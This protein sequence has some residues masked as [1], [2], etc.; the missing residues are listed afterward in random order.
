MFLEKSVYLQCHFAQRQ[1]DITRIG[2]REHRQ[3]GLFR[4]SFL[5]DGV[6]FDVVVELCL[7]LE[8]YSNSD[9]LCFPVNSATAFKI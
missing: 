1:Y 5:F 8:L 4:S 7:S 6:H 9:I 3:T 2:M